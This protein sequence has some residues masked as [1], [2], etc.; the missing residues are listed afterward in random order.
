MRW[1]LTLLLVGCSTREPASVK[2]EATPPTAPSPSATVNTAG[3]PP[4][5]TASVAA[6]APPPTCK[7]VCKKLSDD[8]DHGCPPLEAGRGCLKKCGCKWIGCQRRCDDT[9]EVDF[10]CH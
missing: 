9:G 6:S 8:C 10:T 4:P 7:Q 1:L 3:A 2:A 5:V